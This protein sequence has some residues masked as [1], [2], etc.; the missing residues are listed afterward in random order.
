[1]YFSLNFN[2]GNQKYWKN[3]RLYNR[4]YYFEYDITVEHIS[5]CCIHQ[6]LEHLLLKVLHIP[7]LKVTQLIVKLQTSGVDYLVVAHGGSVVDDEEVHPGAVV[8]PREEL[9]SEEEVL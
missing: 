5:R 6:L 8:E 4:R 9:G 2:I 7:V 3:N 1:M